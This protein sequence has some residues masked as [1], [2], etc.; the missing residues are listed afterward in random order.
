MLKGFTKHLG[1]NS[2]ALLALF[3][4]LGGTS[5]AAASFINGKQIKPGSLPKNRLT[6]SAIRSLKGAKGVQGL[7]GQRGP[8]GPLGPANPNASTLQGF[9]A[10]SLARATTASAG[11]GAD[12][13]NGNVGTGF[14]NFQSTTFTNAISK[15][16]A[17]PVAGVLVIFGHVSSEY[18]SG[19]GPGTIRMLGRL[20]VDGAQ[21][22]QQGEASLSNTTASCQEGRTIALDAAVAVAAGNH[23]VAFQIAKSLTTGG[24]GGAWVGNA[25][26]TTLFVPFGNAGSQ[27]ILGSH[28]PASHSGVSNH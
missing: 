16:V 28:A 3:L 6:K 20:A 7:P 22:G 18:S 17:A 8:T 11:A 15:S 25:S 2:I 13:C 24:T 19:S 12:P 5:F 4:A 1:R 10:T 14:N 27:G 26:V 23:T 21:K 9:A